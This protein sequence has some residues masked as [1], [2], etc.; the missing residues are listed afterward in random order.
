MRARQIPT[1]FLWWATG[2]IVFGVAMWAAVGVFLW[3]L[4][5]G[6]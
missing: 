5:R 2:A 6:C 1:W 4:V 3:C